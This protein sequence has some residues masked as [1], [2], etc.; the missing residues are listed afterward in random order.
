MLEEIRFI[1]NIGRFETAKNNNATFKQCTLMFGENGWGKSTLADIFRS[2]TTTN[3]A[4]LVGRKTL[5]ATVASKAVLRFGTATANFT[6]GTWT[7][8]QPRIV[9]YDT[10]FINDNVYSGD[11]VSA[12]HLKRQFGLVVGEKG[13]Q[14]V[15]RLVELDGE[16][17]DNN[18]AIAT[19][20]AEIN[21]IHR[22]VASAGMTID[23]FL[24]LPA[25]PDID[26]AITS[27]NTTL[28]TLRRGKELK[29]ATEPSLLP[30]P[31]D[32]PSLRDL[33]GQT[34]DGIAEAA[35]ARLRAHIAAHEGKPD[36]AGTVH[37]SWLQSGHHFVKMDNCPFCG[38]KLIDRTL[39]DVYKDYFSDAYKTLAAS[40]KKTRD[41][42][43]RY[44]SGEFKAII[45]AT[46]TSNTANIKF[47]QEAA[48]FTPPQLPDT[49]SIIADIENAASDLDKVFLGKQTN[50]VQSLTDA[51]TQA[52]LAKW[53]TARSKITAFNQALSAF[54]TSIKTLKD[55]IDLSKLPQ[56]EKDAGVLQAIK[57]RHQTDVTDVVAKLDALKR[58]KEAIA[59]E[60]DRVRTALNDHGRS[61]TDD[62]GK[63]I[64]AYLSRLAAGFKIDYKEPDYRSK[65][66]TATYNILIN[67]VPVSP[68]VE[69]IDKPSFR[70]TLSAG[71]KSI[72]AFALFL[73]KLNI[74]PRLNETIVVLDDPFT[75]LDN[76]RRQFIAIEIKKLCGRAKQVIVMSHEKNFLR[77]LWDKI[78]HATISSV[79]L[80]TGA[81]GMATFVPYD[82]AASTQPR[83]ITERMQIEEFIEGEGNH[84][85]Q[86]IRTR[87]R[88]VC[89]DF[90]R[91]GDPGLFGE[92]ASL[93]VII[94]RLEEAGADHPYKSALEDLR[95]INE[96]SRGDNHAAVGGNPAEETTT[97]ELKEFC[98]RV[99][100]LTRGM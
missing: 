54:Q 58:K 80:Q 31:T 2:L 21:G 10:T 85:P 90:Y 79:A 82:I 23:A 47:W 81:P 3:P 66:P 7:G 45:A 64:N 68:R 32:T 5:T 38:Q 55:S 6:D 61:I 40:I 91:K 44:N 69:N 20:Q 41:T 97:D 26:Q 8:P 24:A 4:I 27:L 36:K 11:T 73:A 94:R 16:N 93:E 33:L 51:T 63:A 22:S 74:D 9:I 92:A 60:K 87:L 67:D 98:R 88:T 49:N 62:I 12:E 37:E 46:H 65:E 84:N 34:V 52:A 15:R 43:A 19:A 83:H 48:K 13:V 72:L 50:L 56:M 70:N 25:R 42:F 89:E 17:R 86:Y 59:A 29:A 35:A 18:N 100:A 77:L 76:S 53:D 30:I 75:S 96:Y 14:L 39:I 1:Q 57:R 95:D 71:D 78:D 99:L 28:D